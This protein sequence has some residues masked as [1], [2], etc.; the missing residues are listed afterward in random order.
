M[1]VFSELRNLYHEKEQN[2]LVIFVGAGISENYANIK[3]GKKFPSWKT[4]V[5][6]LVPD[7]MDKTTIVDSLKIAQ[8]FQDNSSKEALAY[9]IKELFPQDYDSHE[10]HQLI[11]DLEPAHV[12]TTNY[13]HLLE[14]ALQ[15]NGL[16]NKYHII[17]ADE[18][19]P[20]SRSK[21]NLLVKA[22]GDIC[23]GNIVLSEQDYNEY[24]QKF[25][26]ILSFIRYVFSKY[27]VLFIGFSLSDPNFNKILF[28]VKNILDE[29]SIKHTVI[30]HNDISESERIYFEKKS[31]RVLTKNEIVGEIIDQD[32]IKRGNE[33]YL[34]ESLE[35]I[36]NGYPKRLYSIKNR[37][38]ILKKNL[39]HA[40]YFK[41]LIPEIVSGFFWN[42][43]LE[44]NHYELAES[45]ES[46]GRKEKRY[47]WLANIYSVD[48]EFNL[49]KVINDNTEEID[50]EFY[51]EYLNEIFEIFF[52]ANIGSISY[53]SAPEYQKIFLKQFNDLYE[54]PEN[55]E[56]KLTYQLESDKFVDIDRSFDK[57]SPYYN[58]LCIANDD[59]FTHY[60][61]GDVRA[62]DLVKR[63]SYSDINEKY[64]YYYRLHYFLSG[65]WVGK[66]TNDKKLYES[67]FT[68]MDRYSQKVFASLH[69]VQ[70]A[71]S[72]IDYLLKTE[73]NFKE[74]Q[75]SGI[76]SF[77]GY[78]TK[79]LYQV[80][81][82]IQYSRFLKFIFLNKLPVFQ[83]E[84]VVT[85]IHLA[86]QFY[87]NY[88]FE[89]KNNKV[90][91][92]N[93]ILLGIALDNKPKEIREAIVKFH[94]DLFSKKIEFEFDIDYVKDFLLKNIELKK[95]DRCLVHF[96]NIFYMLGLFST[97]EDIFDVSLDVFLQFVKSDIK[98]IDNFG[99][100]LQ[101]AVINFKKSNNLF[102]KFQINTIKEILNIYVDYKLKNEV[103]S[104]ININN[105]RDIIWNLEKDTFHDR[106]D[107]I[108]E[109]LKT[110][111][112]GLKNL[113]LFIR[114]L[115]LLGYTDED[116]GE[117]TQK[118]KNI[119]D[120][121]T[122]Y[123]AQEYGSRN[124]RSEIENAI[125]TF[126][127][128]FE[129]N[130]GIEKIKDHYLAVLKE[131]MQDSGYSGVIGDAFEWLNLFIDN[132][133]FKEEIVNELTNPD[134]FNRFSNQLIAVS[135]SMGKTDIFGFSK[136]LLKSGLYLFIKIRRFDTIDEQL[137]LALTNIDVIK[138]L[139]S[140]NLINS[141]NENLIEFLN[142]LSIFNNK[143]LIISLSALLEAYKR[144]DMELASLVTIMN[145]VI[146]EYSKKVL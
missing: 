99:E 146:N 71:Q 49:I 141:Y 18:A 42:T 114:S 53:G 51:D 92:P 90:D 13:D 35:F 80:S 3:D 44:F 142:A 55:V 4:L 29:N 83:D 113:N 54:V 87:F 129:K 19:I 64:L 66:H 73:Q 127:L 5:D 84:R 120:E 108:C 16:D 61:L 39:Q 85:A 94:N 46:D 136:P 122:F 43:E 128:L 26:L 20:L 133:I 119:F 58:S 118:I 75:N 47:P 88:F 124:L 96:E 140:W 109:K 86:N 56:Y 36:K 82:Y 23:R 60:L 132:G 11:F 67:I 144:Q 59:F 131:N 137:G 38:N 81:F 78:D 72:F 50:K 8:I 21:Q 2:N 12:L 22:H 91:I 57:N 7:D 14:K 63:E 77:G 40:R 135:A 25:P 125:L 97:K 76:R 93:W 134:I 10:I 101:I 112:I 89:V 123:T 28:W 143:A 70:F 103:E 24:E 52:L 110:Q 138:F 41:Y 69:H 111:N 139:S 15:V 107:S 31:V 30:L 48:G 62:Y 126:Y 27:K 45:I 116:I 1:K 98:Y 102:S 34:V 104:D 145:G 130:V 37:F 115:W 33:L 32:S 105:F 95:S 121:E 17:D 68:S 117:V 65:S 6:S 106:Q 9:K 100:A 79:D 74:Y